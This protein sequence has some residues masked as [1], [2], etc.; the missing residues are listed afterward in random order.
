MPHNGHDY[1]GHCLGKVL[2]HLMGAAWTV[3][4]SYGHLAHVLSLGSWNTGWAWAMS[5]YGHRLGMGDGI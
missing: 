1:L 4:M 5:C 3:T 2:C